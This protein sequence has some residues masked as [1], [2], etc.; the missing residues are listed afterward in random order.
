MNRLLLPFLTFCLVCTACSS[1]K[2]Q[3]VPDEIQLP[4]VDISTVHV[5]GAKA[6]LTNARWLSEP[7]GYTSTSKPSSTVGIYTVSFLAQ[8]S[9]RIV[10]SGLAGVE[11][12]MKLIAGQQKVITDELFSLMTQYGTVLQVQ[13]PDMLNRSTNRE[14]ALDTYV[15]TLDNLT[16]LMQQKEAEMK[17]TETALNKQRKENKAAVQALE[18]EIKEAFRNEQFDTAAGKQELLAEL[19][20]ALTKTEISLKQNTD[21]QSRFTDL[22]KIGTKRSAAIKANRRIL[23]AGLKV[24]DVPG[25]DEFDLI[26]KR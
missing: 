4:T 3:P 21:M 19:E 15:D 25:V 7:R 18:R 2:E 24:I 11:A 17:T 20:G 9:F 5:S 6:G 1:P 26:Q 23:I 10:K 22:L 12:Q 14:K 8:G 16:T 13:V